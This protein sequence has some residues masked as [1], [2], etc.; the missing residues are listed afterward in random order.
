MPHRE[1]PWQPRH[2]LQ[3]GNDVVAPPLPGPANRAYGFPP[4]PRERNGQA[5]D[6]ASKEETAPTGVDVVSIGSHQARFSPRPKTKTP[7]NQKRV[8]EEIGRRLEPPS[9]KAP[10][11]RWKSV[12]HQAPPQQPPLLYK[13]GTKMAESESGRPAASIGA[14][15]P[16]TTGLGGGPPCRPPQ[17]RSGMPPA[18]TRQL[19]CHAGSESAPGHHQHEDTGGPHH[20]VLCPSSRHG[21]PEGER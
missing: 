17:A 12:D 3:E 8:D 16:T 14:A 15:T 4:V 21:H 2:H 19:H 20:G 6:H 18:A 10:R 9:Q 13:S 7:A 1:L 5:Q 11:C